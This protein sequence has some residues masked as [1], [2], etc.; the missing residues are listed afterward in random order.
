M[1][2]LSRLLCLVATG[3]L[4]AADARACGAFFAQRDDKTPVPFLSVE[5]VL[6]L[7]DRDTE[8]EELVREARFSKA[9]QKFGF[10][11][12]KPSQ[13]EV[14]KVDGEPFTTLDRAFPFEAP[15]PPRPEGPLGM[16]GGPPPR[17]APAP[18]V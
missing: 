10:V 11:V 12:P 6:L 4:A 3:V 16:A 5:Q 8:T 7:W 18:V 15:P 1:R 13:P 14:F 17:A 9:R 2:T